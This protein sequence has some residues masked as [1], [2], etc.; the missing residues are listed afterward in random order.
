M[1][2]NREISIMNQTRQNII[3]LMSGYSIEQLN[4]IPPGY[5]NNLLWNLGHI[6]ITQQ[7]LCYKLSGQKMHLDSELI[8]KYK[9]GSAPEAMISQDEYSWMKQYAGE[10]SQ[11]LHSDYESGLFIEYNPYPTS[12]G[13]SLN[14]IEEAISFNNMHEAHHYGYC[15]ALRKSIG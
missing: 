7:L 8:S 4:L 14:S 12:Y 10:S 11:Q 13:V 2:I 15:L 9:I 6:L 3:K 1:D 5:N